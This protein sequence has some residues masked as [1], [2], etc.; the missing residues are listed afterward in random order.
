MVLI[1][2]VLVVSH[3]CFGKVELNQE[4]FV[5]VGPSSVSPGHE[6][7]I[8]VALQMPNGDT[9]ASFEVRNKKLALSGVV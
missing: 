9:S 2:A 6:F 3:L 1:G 8:G 4:G 7:E 5:E